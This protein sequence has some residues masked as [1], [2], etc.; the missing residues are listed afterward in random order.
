[1][2]DMVFVGIPKNIGEYLQEDEHQPLEESQSKFLKEMLKIGKSG[3]L[4]GIFARSSK[5]ISQSVFHKTCG[6]IPRGIS[7]KYT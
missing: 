5:K 7:I 4:K 3:I 6:R 2:P 1:M